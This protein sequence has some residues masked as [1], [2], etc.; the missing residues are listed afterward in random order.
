MPEFFTNY[1]AAVP[2][3]TSIAD[4]V[5]NMSAL[6]KYNQEQQLMPI[7]LEG[8][9]AELEK[10]QQGAAEGGI[11][12]SQ[13]RQANQENLAVQEAIRKNPQSFMTN[14]RFD[15]NK[16]MQQLPTLAPMTHTDYIKKYTDAMTS[17]ANAE[18][19]VSKLSEDRR[20]I[21]GSTI[22]AL[23]HAGV[24]NPKIVIRAL[25]Q[26]KK[27]HKG[28]EAFSESVDAFA[29]MFKNAMPGSHI[30]QT[31]ILTGNMLLSPSE[32]QQLFAPKS[33]TQA[34]GNVVQPTVNRPSV[35]GEN[36]S[37]FA[38]G[39]PFQM[40]LSPSQREE[41]SGADIYGNPISTVKNVQGEVTGQRGV[42]VIGQNAPA[43]MP[44]RLRPGETPDSVKAFQAE[45][46]NAKDSAAAAAPALSNIQTVRKYLPLAATGANSEAIAKLQSVV[47]N[48]GGSKPEEL[49]AASRDI[50]EKSIAD[51]AL[52]KNQALGGRFVE[53][54]KG[55]SQ[56]LASAGKNPTAIAKSM[57]QLEPLI[58]HAQL[59]QRGLENAINKSGGDVQVKRQFDNEMIGAYDPQALTAYNAY[60]S[61][62]KDALAKAVS[63]MSE[64]KK[65]EIFAK[66]QRYNKLVNGE[67]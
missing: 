38:S 58:Q 22:S 18:S 52:Q 26:L 51:L 19:A 3:Q 61:G 4:L 20:G 9:K 13:T 15:P 54:L 66:M 46:Q 12:L 34:L 59:Y 60:K 53:D 56:S 49:A 62:G 55:A 30:S 39:Q 11:K 36:P 64:A 33:G 21:I 2:K 44:I 42:P 35:L 25:D 23:G 31:A 1:S 57:D 8:A 45:R 5:G 41:V 47:G 7:Q 24:D 50:I 63:G 29:D 17:A 28:D 43:P 48:I 37:L 16:L 6:Q 32:Q 27:H 67:L 40:G 14:G 10:A 65:A